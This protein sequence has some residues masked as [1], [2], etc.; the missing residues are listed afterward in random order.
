MVSPTAYEAGGAAGASLAINPGI[1]QAVRYAARRRH[2]NIAV[3]Q[4]A[5]EQVAG[6][7]LALMKP[8]EPR[9]PGA[10]IEWRRPAADDYFRLGEEAVALLGAALAGRG[11]VPPRR[12]SNSREF[13]RRTSLSRRSTGWPDRSPRSWRDRRGR[14]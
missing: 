13:H 8:F 5:A 10:Q 7:G 9:C 12:R 11:A 6:V 4:I 1:R 2:H 14:F 3:P